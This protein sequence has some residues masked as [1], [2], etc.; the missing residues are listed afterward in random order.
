MAVQD[1]YQPPL[2]EIYLIFK[3]CLAGFRPHVLSDNGWK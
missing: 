3:N 2:D 1:M